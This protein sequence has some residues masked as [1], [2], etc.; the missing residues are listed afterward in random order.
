MRIE[1]VSACLCAILS[2]LDAFAQE[3]AL[4]FSQTIDVD[5]TST[6]GSS[7]VLVLDAARETTIAA[8][9]SN[10]D[11]V[12]IVSGLAPGT[13]TFVFSAAGFAPTE[14][15]VIV[16]EVNNVY[17]LGQIALEPIDETARLQTVTIVGQA[18]QTVSIQPGVNA[19]SIGDRRRFQRLASRPLEGRYPG[20]RLDESVRLADAKE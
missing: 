2:S 3:Q 14:R 1:L 6:I 8:A 10:A 4:V 17:N 12:V 5:G 20:S 18:N 15:R 9:A 19:Y 16:S 13:Y 7:S 11:G